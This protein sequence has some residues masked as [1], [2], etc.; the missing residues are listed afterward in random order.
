MLAFVY[1]NNTYSSWKHVLK[2]TGPDYRVI[3]GS[4]PL[5]LKEIYSLDNLSL[6]AADTKPVVLKR[7][8]AG[9]SKETLTQVLGFLERSDH[10][11]FELVIWNDGK[12]DAR[13]KLYTYL[14]KNAGEVKDFDF[15]NAVQLKEWVRAQGDSFGIKLNAPQADKIIMRAGTDQYVLESELVKLQL[16]LESYGRTD[17][18]DADLEIIS[19]ADL[20]GDI[21]GLLDAVSGRNKVQMLRQLNRL[22]QEQRDFS[23]LITMLARQIKLLYLLKN[24][25][26]D[27][28]KVSSEFKFHPYVVSK[29]KSQLFRFELKQLSTLFSKLA[30]LD[31][32]IKEGKIEPRLGLNLLVAT[33]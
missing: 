27:S 25:E 32:A 10:K 24:P 6:F 33:L 20:E 14:K 28:G 15:L 2:L 17:V 8:F 7:V 16:L 12:V 23:Y 30:G 22:L 5:R 4:D 29:A 18:I 3:D 11:N 21:W 19:K 13:T 31:L 26:I 1:G 9:R